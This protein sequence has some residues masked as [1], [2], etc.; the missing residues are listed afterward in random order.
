M[1]T[2]TLENMIETTA[3]DLYGD[4]AHATVATIRRAC[5]EAGIGFDKLIKMGSKS[6]SVKWI[7]NT[8]V[9]V[10]VKVS[11]MWKE[12]KR[13]AN[14]GSVVTEAMMADAKIA[15]AVHALIEDEEPREIHIPKQHYLIMVEKGECCKYYRGISDGSL[16]TSLLARHANTS[17]DLEAVKA[18]ATLLRDRLAER[19]FVVRI[20]K[21]D[22]R[23]GK[24][25]GTGR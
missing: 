17:T 10:I 19:G 11:S 24:V 5:R 3:T 21:C 4:K 18:R 9:A 1:T 16:H 15:E 13:S 12:Q 20:Q 22:V 6:G 23:N 2:L 14:R 8:A 7:G 25:V